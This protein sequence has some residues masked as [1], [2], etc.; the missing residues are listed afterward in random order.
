[1]ADAVSRKHPCP[2]CSY[3][4]WCSDERCRLCLNRKGCGRR[5]LSMAE[6]IRLYDSLNRDEADTPS[7]G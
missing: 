5:K 1:M 4:Q 7:K 6:Q 2:D 3:C